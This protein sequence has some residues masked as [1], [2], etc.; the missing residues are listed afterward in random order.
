MAGT[1]DGAGNCVGNPAPDGTPCTGDPYDI[2]H[3]FHPCGKYECR[4]GVCSLSE[5]DSHVLPG[6]CPPPPDALCPATT[7]DSLTRTCQA[8][9]YANG[10]KVCT[11]DSQCCG[12]Q[13]C[14]FPVACGA[15]CFSKQCYYPG[16]NVR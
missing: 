8:G 6:V 15:L 1:C 12:G 11:S 5:A 10:V 13:V 4:S 9:S 3:T 2:F 7:C 14:S 16:T